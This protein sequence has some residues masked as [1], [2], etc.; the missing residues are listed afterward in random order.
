MNDKLEYLIEDIYKKNI[1]NEGF[2]DFINPINILNKIPGASSI[3]KIKDIITQIYKIRNSNEF[4]KVYEEIKKISEAENQ[5]QFIELINKIIINSLD[6][7]GYSVPSQIEN[8]KKIF[9]DKNGERKNKNVIFL[10]LIKYFNIILKQIKPNKEIEI[11]TNSFDYTKDVNLL[12]EEINSFKEQHFLY[13]AVKLKQQPKKIPKQVANKIQGLEKKVGSSGGVF[14]GII[15]SLLM[16][17]FMPSA[18]ILSKT[19]GEISKGMGG[20]TDADE[21]EG[22]LNVKLTEKKATEKKL[23]ADKDTLKQKEKLKSE[24]DVKKSESEK[25]LDELKGSYF[26][27]LNKSK[28]AELEKEINDINTKITDNDKDLQ[29]IKNDTESNI[30]KIQDLDSEIET[31]EKLETIADYKNMDKSKLN[32]ITKDVV[33][34]TILD[35]SLKYTNQADSELKEADTLYKDISSKTLDKLKDNSAFKSLNKATQDNFIKKYVNQNF[36]SELKLIETH[37]KLADE[38]NFKADQFLKSYNDIDNNKNLDNNELLKAAKIQQVMKIINNELSKETSNSSVN[39]DIT[40][41]IDSKGNLSIDKNSDYQQMV[42]DYDYFKQNLSDIITEFGDNIDTL[43]VKDIKNIDKIVDDINDLKL[44]SSK[45]SN[46]NVKDKIKEKINEKQEEIK[47]LLKTDTQK[48][49]NIRNV[50]D[51]INSIKNDFAKGDMSL[52]DTLMIAKILK[53]DKNLEVKKVEVKDIKKSDTKK[54]DVKDIK[55]SDIK[56]SD[57]KDIKKSDTKKSDVKDLKLISLGLNSQEIKDYKE[58]SKN[59]T[60]DWDFA[61]DIIFIKAMKGVG[62]NF[63]DINKVVSSNSEVK[64]IFNGVDKTDLWKLDKTD[65]KYKISSE[66]ANSFKKLINS[67]TVDKKTEPVLDKKA[68]EKQNKKNQ[69]ELNKI[70]TTTKKLYFANDIKDSDIKNKIK[71]SEETKKDLKN[72]ISKYKTIQDYKEKVKNLDIESKQPMSKDAYVYKILD[73]TN[74]EKLQKNVEKELDQ[75]VNNLKKSDVFNGFQVN[76]NDVKDFI[77]N[78]PSIKEIVL[79]SKKDVKDLFSILEQNYLKK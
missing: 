2:L 68:S 49:P 62:L 41:K 30:K 46:Q 10:N 67:K 40:Y 59:K 71:N 35:N 25:K 55:K 31:I 16:Y 8:L 42:K 57:V 74:Q 6:K 52:K 33:K 54:S 19:I 36:K 3:L 76:T 60:G 26:S 45:T 66:D 14:F 69:D 22:S 24:L 12:L 18:G 78:N 5:N 28:I 9:L 63:S 72:F 21:L 79:E 50:I 43:T 15:V 56:K 34:K 48:E 44:E 37:K 38:Y 47:E 51:T 27:F 32:E 61:D 39:Y 53:F 29:N 75:I 4:K 17:L 70:D 13:E 23:E 11:Q 7:I 64:N 77:D 1:Y 73:K 65:N 58:L 20:G